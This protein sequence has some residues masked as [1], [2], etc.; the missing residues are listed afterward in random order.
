MVEEGGAWQIYDVG[1]VDSLLWLYH[2]KI[3]Q[4]KLTLPK[5][6]SITV[7]FCDV[8]LHEHVEDIRHSFGAYPVYIT[9]L[10]EDVSLM[11]SV[12]AEIERALQSY[13][14]TVFTDYIIQTLR[15]HVETNEYAFSS[16][17]MSEVNKPGSI[18]ATLKVQIHSSDAEL[19]L[20]LFDVR[21]KR[22]L[23]QRDT[24]IRLEPYE[25][26]A[27]FPASYRLSRQW[28]RLHWETLYTVDVIGMFGDC[29]RYR[30]YPKQDGSCVVGAVQLE[31]RR[32]ER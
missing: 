3:R 31:Q 10:N 27:S 15:D 23:I 26:V 28:Y 17:L 20:E 13:D 24:V 29:F 12:L 21:Q 22:K 25:F 8:T 7:L 9:M 5:E 14:V 18:R 1:G 32:S 11:P 16:R 6:S 2:Q 30:I 4:L 19:I